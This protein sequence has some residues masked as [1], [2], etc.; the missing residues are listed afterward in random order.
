MET[1]PTEIIEFA[2]NVAKALED[3]WFKELEYTN[4]IIESVTFAWD[5]ETIPLK[6]EP[7][8]FDR[9]EMSFK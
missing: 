8:D 6:L 3:T 5:G 2:L 1:Y 9:L 7:S 4:V